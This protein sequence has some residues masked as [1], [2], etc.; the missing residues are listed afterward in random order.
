MRLLRFYHTPIALFLL[1]VFSLYASSCRM[2]LFSWQ[3]TP[4][5]QLENLANK[6]AFIY[7]TDNL[8]NPVIVW[9]LT[10][11][12]IRKDALIGKLQ[13]LSL[14]EIEHMRYPKMPRKERK[15]A[16]YYMHGNLKAN[17][18]QQ[19]VVVSLKPGYAQKLLVNPVDSIDTAAIE[20]VETYQYDRNASHETPAML[21]ALASFPVGVAILILALSNADFFGELK[22]GGH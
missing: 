18:G 22:W 12:A 17:P 3:E 16:S 7:I 10:P 4:S 15:E 1:L 8:K 5:Q 19:Y 9:R 20:T 13:L 6:S 2:Y 11:S 21:A 14:K